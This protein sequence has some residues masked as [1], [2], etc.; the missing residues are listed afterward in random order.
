MY[1]IVFGHIMKATEEDI[2]RKNTYP[3][4]A[5]AKVALIEQATDRV[6][7]S[8]EQLERDMAYLERLQQGTGWML[9]NLENDTD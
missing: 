7:Q 3:T 1:K 9:Y 2:G 6:I 4:I 8:R 5:A